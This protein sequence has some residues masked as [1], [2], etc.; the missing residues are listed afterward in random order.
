VFAF[1][2]ASYFARSSDDPITRFPPI[3]RF[4]P[5]AQIVSCVFKLPLAELQFYASG[6]DHTSGNQ[7]A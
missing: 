7:R 6:K 5:V 4:F 1:G 2:F 3:T